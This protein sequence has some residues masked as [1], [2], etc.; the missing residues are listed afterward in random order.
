MY[1][2]WEMMGGTL[3]PKL[4]SPSVI[5]KLVVALGD[6]YRIQKDS[7]QRRSSWGRAPSARRQAASGFMHTAS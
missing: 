2:T 5:E 3:N 7:V 4:M 6:Q 1:T